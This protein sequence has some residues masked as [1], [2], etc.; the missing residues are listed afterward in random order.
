[1]WMISPELLCTKHLL[2]EHGEIHKHRHN[3]VKK[4]NI[5]NRVKLNQIEPKSM[6]TRH[7]ELAKEMTNRGF[8]HHSDYEMPDISYLPIEE[9]NYI[10]DIVNSHQ[11]L[12]NRCK[13][14]K[15]KIKLDTLFHLCYYIHMTFEEL[16]N[17]IIP[18]DRN[19]IDLRKRRTIIKTIYK[20]AKIYKLKV[21]YINR[22]AG[23]YY[24]FDARFI[25]LGK[26]KRDKWLLQCFCHEL[27]HDIQ[28]T[29]GV[30]YSRYN[31]ADILLWEREGER[32][33]YFIFQYYFSKKY[34]LHHKECAAYRSRKDVDFLRKNWCL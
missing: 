26:D 2:G 27:A 32:L 24:D 6:K 16:K 15:D 1:M 13:N 18:I 10:V 7:D 29:N 17:C 14:C 3:F 9:Q 21:Q 33:S 25:M 31:L 8:K 4:H 34:K 12:C 11:D 30:K 28:S 22:N 19:I 23:G 20:I 5:H